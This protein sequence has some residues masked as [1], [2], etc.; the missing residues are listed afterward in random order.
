MRQEYQV[1]VIE[2]PEVKMGKSL[3]KQLLLK[4]PQGNQELALKEEAKT[5]TK[6]EENTKATNREKARYQ[7]NL[8]IRGPKAHPS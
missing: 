7:I 2:P 3:V 8:Q 5:K 6:I 4:K 1:E